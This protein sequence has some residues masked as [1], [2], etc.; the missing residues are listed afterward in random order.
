MFVGGAAVVVGGVVV[1]VAVVGGAA[2]VVVGVTVEAGGAVVEVGG[3]EEPEPVGLEPSRKITMLTG[4]NLS[5]ITK[6]GEQ[7]CQQG[8]HA[9]PSFGELDQ[10]LW[11]KEV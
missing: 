9:R 5:V 7:G 3:V 10:L 4:I 8:Q 2:V 11:G 1:V 6:E